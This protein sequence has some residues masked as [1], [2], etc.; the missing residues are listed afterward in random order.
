MTPEELK[1][2]EERINKTSWEF[3]VEYLLKIKE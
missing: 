3:T 2:I 1:D